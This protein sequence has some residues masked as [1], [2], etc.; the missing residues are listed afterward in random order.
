MIQSWKILTQETLAK[1]WNKELRKV[2]FEKPDGQLTDF[3]LYG[4]PHYAV[5]MPVTENGLVVTLR[6]YYQGA[7]KVLSVLPG[8][9]LKK[10]EAPGKAAAR[11]LQEETGYQAGKII[12]LGGPLWPSARNSWHQFHVFLGLDCKKVDEGSG[13][14]GNFEIELVPLKDLVTMTMSEVEDVS[15]VVA[16]HRALPHLKKFLR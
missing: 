12:T 6:Q 1:G 8:G 10:H 14:D 11:E 5:I 16:T 4:Q 7:Q 15:A 13:D 2:T 9:N 3:F